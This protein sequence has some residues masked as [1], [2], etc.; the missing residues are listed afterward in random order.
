MKKNITKQEIQSMNNGDKIYGEGLEIR[1]SISGIAFYACCQVRGQ[2]LRQRL[3]SDQDGMNLTK[4]RSALRREINKVPQQLSSGRSNPNIRFDA[5]ADYYISTL[6]IAGG[7]NID[8]KSQ[9]I[10]MHLKPFFNNRK[11]SSITTLDIEKYQHNRRNSG[12]A[13]STVNREGAT[14]RHMLGKLDEWGIVNTKAIKIKN[15]S[16]ERRKTNIFSDDQIRRILKAAESDFDKYTYL[17]VVI[18]FMTS[19]RHT[20]ILKIKFEDFDH[21]SASLT[22]PEAKAGQRTIPVGTTL[23]EIIRKEQEKRAVKSGY[24]FASESVTGHRTYMKKQFQRCLKAA[25]LDGLGY[26]PHTMR[27]TAITLVIS[28]GVSIADAQVISGHRT[29]SML[30]N[31]VHHNNQAV[32]SAVGALAAVVMNNSDLPEADDLTI[33]HDSQNA[34]LHTEYTQQ[35]SECIW[36]QKGTTYSMNF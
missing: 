1:K 27:H 23:L 34:R 36:D 5:A 2:R 14:L 8:Q 30:L 20:E 21:R 19:M 9:Q 29:T 4:A 25:G 33:N 35:I 6:K 15:L 12:M 7:K 18:G 11:I 13:I 16:G 10:R 28:S 31:Y 22:I 17:F 24:V 3:G 26:T 32:K